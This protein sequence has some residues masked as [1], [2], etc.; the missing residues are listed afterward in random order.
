MSR[1][2]KT[3]I[4]QDYNRKDLQ[5]PFF[6]KKKK[7]SVKIKKS[8]FKFCLVLILAGLIFLIWFFLSAKFFEIK[9]IRIEGL[10]RFSEEEISMYVTEQENNTR[11]GIFKES[12]IFLFDKE[13]VMQ[14]INQE[15][16]FSKLEIRKKLPN[17]L[18][19]RIEERPYAFIFQQGEGFYYSSP[20]GF[21]FDVEVS[22]EA[23][24]H[25]FIL[26]NKNEQNL[27]NDNS[28][29][30]IKDSYIEFIFKLNN[31]LSEEEELTLD[32]FIID[33][34]FNTIKVDFKDGPVV[35][36]NTKTEAE[37]Q[38][39]RLTLVKKEKIRDNFNR[40]EYIDLRY[41]DRIF[42]YPPIN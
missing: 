20:E 42:L 17:I 24:S 15:Y 30:N 13:E 32:R 14:N 1:I 33:Q 4:R 27:I 7:G 18:E 9:E 29:I 38:V 40:V 37:S 16:N 3:K 28:T 8:W 22:E 2:R 26:E 5:N 41:G 39:G 35:F 6:K 12:N 36:F 10:T 31:L 34:E 11:L 23:K 25:Y 19:L 21:I